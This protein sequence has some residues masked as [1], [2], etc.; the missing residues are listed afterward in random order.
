[1]SSY[2][3]QSRE[4]GRAPVD[5]GGR[6]DAWWTE[7]L[8]FGVVF[9]LFVIYTTYRMFENADFFFPGGIGAGEHAATY[10]SPFYSPLLPLQITLH[11]PLLGAKMISPAVYILIFPLA[12]RMTCY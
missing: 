2:T 10:L 7:A 12:F 9:G 11:L 1:M 5:M 3:A 4:P 6:K 8:T